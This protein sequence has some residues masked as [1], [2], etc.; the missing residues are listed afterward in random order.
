MPISTTCPSCKAIFRLAEELAGKKVK[1]QKCQGLFVVPTGEAGTM[2]PGIHVPE[3][4]ELAVAESAAAKAH[5]APTRPEDIPV[6][7]RVAA[8]D[9][10]DR[11]AEEEQRAPSKPRRSERRPRRDENP[12][13][14][15][16]LLP[17]VLALGG[18]G[19]FSCI[20]LIGGM[21]LWHLVADAPPAQPRPM[22][23]V[24][25]R[26]PAFAQQGVPKNGL[27]GGFNL[28][29][30]RPVNQNPAT[31]IKLGAD[32]IFRQESELTVQDSLNPDNKRHKHYAIQLEE[33]KRYQIDL[34]SVHFDAFLFL[35]DNENTKVAENDDV[36]GPPEPGK[37]HNQ[38]SRIIYAPMK[39]GLFK[40]EATFFDNS[41][42]G[43][44]RQLGPFT[45][46]I[47]ELK[48]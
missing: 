37:L 23:G 20:V 26:K 41:L 40:I 7:A 33:G 36:D 28:D 3:E 25:N 5:A 6:M 45:L 48:K 30:V 44:F 17:I 18:L 35:F 47:R 42:G 15:S 10:A 9:D 46:T 12:R 24:R 29:R 2:E 32:G 13:P 38:N 1:C 43:D 39:T 14:K 16:G 19:L 11:D 27:P 8:F 21:A 34:E 4:R 31:E 22:M